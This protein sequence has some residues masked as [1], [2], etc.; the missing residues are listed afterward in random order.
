MTADGRGR[1]RGELKDLPVTASEHYLKLRFTNEDACYYQFHL[2]P[3]FD[4]PFIM[5]AARKRAGDT[6]YLKVGLAHADRLQAFIQN[7]R[8]NPHLVA[9]EESSKEEFAKASSHAV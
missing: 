5:E 3:T 8:G 4:E 9:I 6:Q 7:L 1:L 2:F